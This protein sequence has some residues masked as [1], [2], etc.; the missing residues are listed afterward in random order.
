MRSSLYLPCIQVSDI[1][2]MQMRPNHHMNID[3]YKYVHVQ[4]LWEDCVTYDVAFDDP[5]DCRST[6]EYNFKITHLEMK[7]NQRKQEMEDGS[8]TPI[9]DMNFGNF[10]ELPF[11]KQKK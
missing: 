5:Y 4:Q 6:D 2:C 8:F 11:S 3:S 7:I 10:A 9:P 1:P